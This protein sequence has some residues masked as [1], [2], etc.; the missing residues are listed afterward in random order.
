MSQTV[1]TRMRELRALNPAFPDRIFGYHYSAYTKAILGTIF[2]AVDG[3]KLST[4]TWG[5]QMQHLLL[6]EQQ[7]TPVKCEVRLS[8]EST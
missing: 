2:S 5:E 4:L 1:Y 6:L 8:C 7:M 3:K